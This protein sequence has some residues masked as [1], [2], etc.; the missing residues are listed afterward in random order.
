M[1]EVRKEELVTPRLM[2]ISGTVR[3]SRL[4]PPAER[5]DLAERV[6]RTSALHSMP[7]EPREVHKLA[8]YERS[9]GEQPA[10]V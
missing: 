7:C 1:V 10:D 2:A 6:A 9:L 3:G 4:P 5:S 8:R